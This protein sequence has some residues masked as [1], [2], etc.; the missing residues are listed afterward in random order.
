M[1]GERKRKTTLHDI[2]PRLKIQAIKDIKMVVKETS[3]ATSYANSMF[4]RR[5]CLDCYALMRWCLLSFDFD[6]RLRSLGGRDRFSDQLF[7][8]PGFLFTS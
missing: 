1:N 4:D 5:L 8:V 6:H 2:F 3:K 7:F